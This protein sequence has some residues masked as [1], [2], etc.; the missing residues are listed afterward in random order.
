M[1]D[2]LKPIDNVEDLLKQSKK[3][4]V[5]MLFVQVAG[6]VTKPQAEKITGRWQSSL[7][8]GNIQIQR[9][10]IDDTKAI[11]LLEDG[12]L[13][14]DVKGYLI[15]QPECRSVE[16]EQKMYWGKGAGQADKD[17][18]EKKSDEIKKKAAQTAVLKPTEEAKGESNS[19]HLLM[20]SCMCNGGIATCMW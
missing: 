15:Q 5:L 1:F 3:G 13:A 19:I 10:M 12:S 8:N 20:E 7:F 9:Y 2:P 17:A 4:Q 6:D 16:I 14:W 11:F 18:E